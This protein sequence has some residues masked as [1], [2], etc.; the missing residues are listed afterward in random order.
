MDD[1][2]NEEEDKMV[3]NTIAITI[4]FIVCMLIMTGH[5]LPIEDPECKI[6]HLSQ[7]TVVHVFMLLTDYS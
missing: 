7:A 1:I 6:T 2:Y 3:E 5:T 4:N